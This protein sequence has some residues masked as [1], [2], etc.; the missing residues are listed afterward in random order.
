MMDS[1]I[2]KMVAGLYSGLLNIIYDSRSYKIFSAVS[3]YVKNAAK[4]SV[5]GGF[6]FNEVK[7]KSQ[8]NSFLQKLF[9]KA[10]D[11]STNILNLIK[12]FTASV[13]RNSRI[14]NVM[15]DF[16]CNILFLPLRTFGVMSITAGITY[17]S[18][19][20]I[21][22]EIGPRSIIA[23]AVLITLGGVMVLFKLGLYEI[24]GD[25]LFIRFILGKSGN[26]D[27]LNMSG[28]AVC[29][30]ECSNKNGKYLS[31]LEIVVKS[32]FS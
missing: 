4:K 18:L 26:L 25:S 11:K 30:P 24:F 15:F 28:V 8:E 3:R 19:T 31:P 10:A 29:T 1:M 27:V 9:N 17:I 14:I 7:E 6:F 12:S 2:I 32:R 16:Y 21:V 20:G 13:L 22:N 5:I 23:C